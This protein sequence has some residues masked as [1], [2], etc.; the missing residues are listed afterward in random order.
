MR[1]L[2]CLNF[3]TP[4]RTG[5]PLGDSLSVQSAAAELPENRRSLSGYDP[6]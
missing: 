3:G 5:G 2:C 6:D 1:T 4:R